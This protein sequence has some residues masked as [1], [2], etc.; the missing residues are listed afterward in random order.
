MLCKVYMINLVLIIRYIVRCDQ[1]C[2]DFKIVPY[3]EMEQQS[4]NE[5]NVAP[6]LCRNNCGSFGSPAT[7]NFC[8]KCYKEYCFRNFNP[9]IDLRDKENDEKG[10]EKEKSIGEMDE[11]QVTGLV[12]DPVNLS[13]GTPLSIFR[14]AGIVLVVPAKIE[15]TGIYPAST[16]RLMGF[17]CRC[18][19]VFCSV[20]RYSDKHVIS[21][22]FDGI[23]TILST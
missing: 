20:H 10:E 16:V 6:I 19:N 5:N 4:K 18:G 11:A 7:N 3:N 23:R 21:L 14:P 8:S 15:L 9:S 1:L 12:V 2:I 22:L 13:K 17:Q